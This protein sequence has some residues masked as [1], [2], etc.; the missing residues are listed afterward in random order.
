[1]TGDEFEAAYAAESGISVGRLRELGRV[2]VPCA[3]G[4]PLC[5]G[6]ASIPRDCS[7]DWRHRGIHAAS[8]PERHGP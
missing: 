3:C 8:H 7:G 4:D 2:V 6:W 5:R 1:M